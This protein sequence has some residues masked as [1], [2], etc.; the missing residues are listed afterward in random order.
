MS[1]TRKF[2]WNGVDKKYPTTFSYDK[3]KL[4]TD[5]SGRS[6]LTGTMIKQ[7]MGKT[8]SITMKWDRLTEDECYDLALIFNDDEGKITFA[9][10]CAG[11]KTDTTWRAYTGDFHAEFLYSTEDDE[12]RYSLTLDFI[13]MDCKK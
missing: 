5:D 9:D 4:Q 1:F 8:R 11:T 12:Y 13:E 10:A 7:D 2:Q 3:S 6:P